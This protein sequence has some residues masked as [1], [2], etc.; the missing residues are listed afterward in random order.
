MNQSNSILGLLLLFVIGVLGVTI[1]LAN[2]DAQR[3]STSDQMSI[4]PGTIALSIGNTYSTLPDLA[5]GQSVDLY[6]QLVNGGYPG[7]LTIVINNFVGVLN[8]TNSR[9]QIPTIGNYLTILPWIDTAV[10]QVP[11]SPVTHNVAASK[12]K[13]IGDIILEGTGGNHTHVM[14]SN[15]NLNNNYFA[16]NQLANI[17]TAWKIPSTIFISEAG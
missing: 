12:T 16:V 3:N 6:H 11:F 13:L 10:N 14:N 15:E 2:A 1:T 4:N 8:A 7:T 5:L 17:G 9:E